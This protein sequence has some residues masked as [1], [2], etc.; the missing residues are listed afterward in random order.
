MNKKDA[1]S[2]SHR[3]LALPSNLPSPFQNVIRK[4][5]NILHQIILNFVFAKD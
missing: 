3:A 2:G 1:L 4:K 5:M